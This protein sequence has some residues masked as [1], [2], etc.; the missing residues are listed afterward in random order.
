MPRVWA[1]NP[2]S[3]SAR[4]RAF[5][6]LLLCSGLLPVKGGGHCPGSPL[7]EVLQAGF[8]V[9]TQEVLYW[10]K[11]IFHFVLIIDQNRSSALL[12]MAGPKAE[13]TRGCACPLVAPLTHFPLLVPHLCPLWS[14]VQPLVLCA[15]LLCR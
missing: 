13:K 15:M 2:F 4:L 6:C 11:K 7:G 12:T 3:L 9:G 10:L 5:R 8:C 1:R 14:F